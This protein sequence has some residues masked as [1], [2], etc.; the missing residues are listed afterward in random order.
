MLKLPRRLAPYIY[1]VFQSGITTAVA[2]GIATV[3]T[4]GLGLDS[5][6]VWLAAWALAWATML[7]VVFFIAPFIQRAVLW[8]TRD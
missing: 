3:Q 7:P 8:M 1:G 2:T 5:A 6:R 4:I